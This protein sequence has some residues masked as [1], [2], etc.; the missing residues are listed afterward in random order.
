[1]II[2]AAQSDE[3]ELIGELRVAAYRDS[4]FV[5]E[6]AG[7][8]ETLRNFGFDDGCVILVAVCDDGSDGLLGTVALE[9]F[10]PHSEL[11][12]DETEADVRA[13]AV[14]SG[15]Q[16]RGVGRALL[17]AVTDLGRQRGLRTL[18]LCTQPAMLAAQHL[19][20][21]AGFARTP[22]LDWSPVPGLTLRAYEL[23][24]GS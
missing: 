12:R 18:R 9:L 20:E 4:G 6:G 21:K 11:A 17:S 8:A 1:M 16:G 22:A 23:P 7:Y 5:S 13:F 24:L 15:T 14:A 10:G 19:Y 3:R 2:R